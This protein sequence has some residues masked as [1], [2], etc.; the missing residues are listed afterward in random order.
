MFNNIVVFINFLSF[1]FILVGVDIKYNDN[2][3][4]IVHV[5]FFIS[6][7]L[8]M[9]TSLISHNRIAYG[10]SQILEILCI[11]CILLLFYILKKTNSLSNRSNVVFIIFVVTQVIIIINQLFIR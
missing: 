10:L 2:R 7:I 9:L 5:T 4:K 3:I 6:F 8:V 1:V 11:I